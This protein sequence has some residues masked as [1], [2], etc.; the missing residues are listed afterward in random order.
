MSQPPSH[1]LTI[2]ALFYGD[3]PDLARRCLTSLERRL[4]M[5]LVHSIRV[6]LNE[7]CPATEDIINQAIDSGLLRERYVYQKTRNAH[8]YPVMREMFYDP[9]NPIETN[10]VMWFDDDSFIRDGREDWTE[11]VLG[12]AEKHDLLGTRRYIRL[13]GNQRAWVQDQPWYRGNPAITKSGQQV[14]FMNGA[15]WVTRTAILQEL[16]YPW[17]ELDH[18]GGDVML[19]VAMQQLGYNLHHFTEGVGI[20]ADQQG[21]EDKS[22]RRGFDQKPLGWNY[23]PGVAKPVVEN[24]GA[25][26]PVVIDMFANDGSNT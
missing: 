26:L 22:R 23:D 21:Q 24:T 8:K 10:Y 17:Q 16:D 2:F 3:H 11:F 12:E 7:V 15:W 6:G 14:S 4:D 20:N 1:K 5:S 13:G 25:G 19:G 18:R 9:D